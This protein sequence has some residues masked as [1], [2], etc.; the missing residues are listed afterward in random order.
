MGNARL[1]GLRGAVRCQNDVADIGSR[2][3]ELYDALITG[4][5]IDEAD[6]VS[7]IFSV[8]PD[9]NAANPA[10]ELRKSGRGLS[11]ALFAVAEAPSEGALERVIRVLVH[12]YAEEGNAPRHAYLNGAEALRPDRAVRPGKRRG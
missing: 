7:F 6:V 4:N 1:Y 3:A 2:V 8:T 11:L 5:G 9:L 10:A 12:C